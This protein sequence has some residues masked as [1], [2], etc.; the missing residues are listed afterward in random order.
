MDV[1]QPPAFL[2][3]LLQLTGVRLHFEKLPSQLDPPKPPL[4]IGSCTG[5]MELIVKLKQNE[6]FPGPK[7]SPRP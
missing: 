5:Y 3:K 6:A 7:V 2:H 4:Q 1:H